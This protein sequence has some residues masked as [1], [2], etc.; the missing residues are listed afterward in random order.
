MRKNFSTLLVTFFYSFLLLQSCDEKSEP[1]TIQSIN[2]DKKIVL[3]ELDRYLN[4]TMDSLRIPGLSFA[5]IEDAK[6]AYHRAIGVT[7]NETSELVNDSTIFEAAS[8]SKPVFAFF[9]LKMAEKSIIDLDRP[10]HF[11]LPDN[12]MDK[13]ERYKSVNARMVLGH[14]TGF[15]NWRWFDLAPEEMKIP[16]GEFYMKAEPGTFTYS[17]EGYDY[18]ARVLANNNFG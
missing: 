13:D 3:V 10:L 7:N 1:N 5:I 9:S 14:T 8:I 17:G 18:L 16:R 11:Y 4:R 15:P 2:A 6:V 12:T